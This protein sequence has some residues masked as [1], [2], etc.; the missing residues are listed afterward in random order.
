M[1][2][3]PLVAVLALALT[4][5][6][7][8]MQALRTSVQTPTATHT[9]TKLQE[10]SLDAATVAA[11]FTVANPNA[12]GVKLDGLDWAFSFDGQKL[13]DGRLPTGLNLPANG[14]TQLTVPITVPFKA[15]P[16]LLTTF[17]SKKEA[18][19]SVQAS[20]TVKTPIGPLTLPLGWEGVLPVPKLPSV[21]LTTARVDTVSLTGA[22][23]TVALAVENP[24]VFRLPL[25]ALGGR[26][27]VGGQPVAS[28]ALSNARALEPGRVTQLELPVD[29]SFASTGLAVTS[30]LTSGRATLA[31]DG[32]AKVGGKAL[33][34]DLKTTLTR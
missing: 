31:L 17:A 27:L 26:V 1:H 11:T 22:R 24:N 18:P 30:A 33:P 10:I 16:S 25:E 21:R 2:R 7:G 14:R 13:F 8:L 9:G 34:F 15:I 5:C 29:I 4:G 6:A 32:Q 12:V 28:V 20:A 3:V 19:Y 23:L